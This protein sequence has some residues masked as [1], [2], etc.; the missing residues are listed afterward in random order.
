MTT[1]YLKFRTTATPGTWVGHDEAASVV[2]SHTDI[3]K[4]FNY[5]KT[6]TIDCVDKTNAPPTVCAK[7]FTTQVKSTSTRT[8]SSADW[9]QFQAI[10]GGSSTN[11]FASISFYVHDTTLAPQF[12]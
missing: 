1:S 7:T 10:A 2:L 4:N 8:N 11:D 9:L 5:L 6:A 3:D 12:G